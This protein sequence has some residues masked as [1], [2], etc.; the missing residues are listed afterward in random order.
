MFKRLVVASALFACAAVVSVIPLAAADDLPPVDDPPACTVDALLVNSCRP[1]FGA[2][3][4]RYPAAPSD[5]TPQLLYFEQRAGRQMDVAHT[6]HGVGNN[7]L[8]STDVYF[9]TR[10]DTYLLVNWRPT[11][12]WSTA[13]GSDDTVNASIDAMAESIKALG[14]TKIFL[15]LFHEPENK[16][17]VAPSCANTVGKG[18]AGTPDEYRAMWANVRARFDAVGVTNVV[19][20][21]NYMNSPPFDCLV[22][23]LYP[24]DDLVDW[25]VFN[26]YQHGDRNVDFVNNVGHM[27][28]L[29][30]AHSAPG[31]D[32]L[33]KPWGIVEWG[34][35]NSTQ[36]N[37]YLYDKQATAAVEQRVFP[38][39]HLYLSF[40]SGNWQTQDF[41]H[42]V[43]YDVNGVADPA[44]Q[45]AFNEFAQS[46]ALL[47][48]GIQ[49][50]T[51]PTVPT[52]LA[53]SMGSAGQVDL[54]WTPASDDSGIASYSVRRD[55]VVIG[56]PAGPAFTDAAPVSGQDHTYSVR[57]M[58]RY[59]NVSD[60]GPPL[61]VTVPDVTPPTRPTR[62]VSALANGAVTLSWSPAQDN[63]AVDH[64]DVLRNGSLIAST[65]TT[66]VTDAAV[67]QGSRYTYTVRA[68]DAAGNVS[69]L[70]ASVSRSVP[71]TIAPTAPAWLK[72]SR[73]SRSA[74]IT[75]GAATDNV[76]VTGYTVYKG[77]TVVARPSATTFKYTFLNLTSGVRYTFRVAARDAAGHVGPALSIV[78]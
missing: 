31:H 34:I 38:R 3:A 10:P 60:E 18:T 2:T 32:Y 67:S 8:T 5:S 62:L 42:R 55:G 48:S 39:L 35:N 52:D 7:T 75:W 73:F 20:V 17:T 26:G 69:P 25:V 46:P 23:D 21:M 70:S 29:L 64:Y 76:G 44:E 24:G 33:S 9:A 54:T 77:T 14:D 36:Q 50:F 1:W 16:V 58:D 27:Y 56:R 63:V 71:D 30:T 4:S 57:A 47:G 15:D 37:A 22:D 74:T 51:P 40:D 45:A 65:G 61:T 6:Y 59:G 41:S 68:V 78:G 66:S 28:D 49:D 12:T 53:A 13:G 72:V 43:G 19:W 11:D